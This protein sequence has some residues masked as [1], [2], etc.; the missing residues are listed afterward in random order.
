[1]KLFLLL[2]CLLSVQAFSNAEGSE[3]FL[4]DFLN[5]K[6]E[7]TECI[8]YRK[9]AQCLHDLCKDEKGDSLSYSL[10]KEARKDIVQ[11]VFERVSVLSSSKIDVFFELIP[12]QLKTNFVYCSFYRANRH[13]KSFSA[14]P[15]EF[16]KKPLALLFDFSDEAFNFLISSFKKPCWCERENFEKFSSFIKYSGVGHFNCV[17]ENERLRK[18]LIPYLE[19]SFFVLFKCGY[20]TSVIDVLTE[21]QYSFMKN[22]KV[23]SVCFE[24]IDQLDDRVK[25]RWIEVM[26]KSAPIFFRYLNF[27][28]KLEKE[29]PRLIWNSL[30]HL[31]KEGV[32]LNAIFRIFKGKDLEC[33]MQII[34]DKKANEYSCFSYQKTQDD[35]LTK[36]FIEDHKSFLFYLNFTKMSFEDFSETF[37]EALGEKLEYNFYFLNSLPDELKNFHKKLVESLPE[38]KTV[39]QRMIKRVE[40]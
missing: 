29:S 26:S 27:K 40:G 30:N 8:D 2:V 31:S 13:Q 14:Q 35:L 9:I 32:P 15:A 39:N 33:L 1:M 17:F 25:S 28:K 5:E 22:E 38:S 37:K 20:E 21:N 10:L 16:T 24:A 18:E 11:R 23:L 3:K 4:K 6:I 7:S 34:K 19:E 12:D 36:M